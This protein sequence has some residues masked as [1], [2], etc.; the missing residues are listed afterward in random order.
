[1]AKF[2]I[3]MEELRCDRCARRVTK[4][5]GTAALYPDGPMKFDPD[6]LG[7]EAPRAAD[8]CNGCWKSLT[9]WWARGGGGEA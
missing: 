8:L 3:K 9:K 2:E 1:M 5:G 6:D 7:A 4:S